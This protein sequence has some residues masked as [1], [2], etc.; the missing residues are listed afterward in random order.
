MVIE[1]FKCDFTCK[2]AKNSYS[3]TSVKILQTICVI[4]LKNRG[5]VTS[6]GQSN[7]VY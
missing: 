7:R 6:T 5:Y 4:S 1:V 3:Y 2:I